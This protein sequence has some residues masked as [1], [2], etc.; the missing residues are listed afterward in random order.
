M[1]APLAVSEEL[2][3]LQIDAGVAVVVTVGV[4]RTV[5]VCVVVPVPRTFVAV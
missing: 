5:I 1:D 2:E 3:P 4:A